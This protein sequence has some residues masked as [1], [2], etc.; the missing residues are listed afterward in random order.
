VS[1]RMQDRMSIKG[2]IELLDST[3]R[4]NVRVNASLNGRYNDR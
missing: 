1:D 3:A 4:H 2:Q